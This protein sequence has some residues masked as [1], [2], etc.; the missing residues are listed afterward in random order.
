M[1][2]ATVAGTAQRA[3]Q[4]V[5]GLAYRAGWDSLTLSALGL[6][7]GRARA[8][9]I[10]AAV[11]HYLAHGGNLL[12][13]QGQPAALGAGLAQ[14]CSAG[15][16]RREHVV[17]CAEGGQAPAVAG[18]HLDPAEVRRLV[19]AALLDLGLARLD[20]FWLAGADTLYRAAGEAVLRFHLR[21]AFAAL[22]VAVAQ[23]EIAAY[24]LALEE[25]LP[26]P[27]ALALEIA[28][29]VL[30][31]RHH[32]RALR[33]P[34]GALAAP[35]ADEVAGL[36]VLATSGQLPPAL[37]ASPTTAVIVEAGAWPIAAR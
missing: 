5:N 13:A 37:A 14:A 22:E 32:L 18:G 4:A 27:S 30:G 36:A 28:H 11:G 19:R 34:L 8:A 35:P 16:L 33:L 21:E 31:A 20:L 15:K 17:V 10:A 2:H 24:G 7:A 3:A 1:D 6:G 26:F 12:D 29:D 23:N 9:D 25:G